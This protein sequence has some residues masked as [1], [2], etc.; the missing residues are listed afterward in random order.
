MYDNF[1]ILLEYP[2]IL[3]LILIQP[4]TVILTPILTLILI[5]MVGYSKQ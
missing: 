4:L 3:I 5:K 1:G 2:T